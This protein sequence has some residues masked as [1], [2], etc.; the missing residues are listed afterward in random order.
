MVS[1]CQ[2]ISLNTAINITFKMKKVSEEQNDFAAKVSVSRKKR[3]VKK[4]DAE[5]FLMEKELCI[6]QL[7]LTHYEKKI[8]N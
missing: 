1:R 3:K 4:V 5:I 2:R 8:M 6:S 7:K